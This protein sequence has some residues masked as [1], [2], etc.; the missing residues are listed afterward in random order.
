MVVQDLAQGIEGLA[1]M[2]PHAIGSYIDHCVLGALASHA[3]LRGSFRCV[4]DECDF[5]K[6]EEVL[7]R[8]REYH[9]ENAKIWVGV[10]AFGP[11]D[12][13]ILEIDVLLVVDGAEP[14]HYTVHAVC[15][16]NEQL[17]HAIVI[18]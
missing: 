7:T 17:G 18:H 15:C 5:D 6:K 9:S 13:I 12:S 4:L 8:S 10:A 16:Y 2:R 14:E 3:D 1:F 11:P